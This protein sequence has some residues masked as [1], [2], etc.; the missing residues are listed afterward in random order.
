MSDSL[1]FRSRTQSSGDR[2]VEQIEAQTREVRSRSNRFALAEAVFVAGGIALLGCGALILLAFRLAPRGFAAAAWLILAGFVVIAVR[3]VAQARRE[4]IPARQA[5]VLIDE[6]A[7][8]EGRLSTLAAATDVSRR[9]R[10]WSFLLHEN[11]RLAPQWEPTRLVPR[12]IPRSVRFFAVALLVLAFALWRIPRPVSG[13][14][15][16]PREV[17]ASGPPS[18]NDSGEEGE[19][20]PEDSDSMPGW[21]ELPE[22]IR[23]AILGSQSSQT[24]AGKLPEKTVPVLEDK[25]G[26]AIVGDRMANGG[27]VRSMPAGPNA[28]KPSGKPGAGANAPPAPNP[29]PATAADAPPPPLLA[30]GDA[31][32]K[33]PPMDSGKPQGPTSKSKGK[34]APGSSGGGGA[35]AGGDADGLYGD[36]QE[37][38]KYSGSFALDLDALQSDQPSKEGDA[39]DVDVRPEGRLAAEQRL[40]DAIRRSQ[41]P[42][43][44]EKIVQRIF[45]R[46]GEDPQP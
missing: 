2:A 30:R 29:N 25:G 44:Y 40:D 34:S 10:L 42:V 16:S 9:S 24:F 5:A 22:T 35:G 18:E 19:Q 37:P 12:A 39:G 23:Q 15:E 31:P 33:L 13:A 3:K 45:N 7:R 20:G 43:E 1:P 8:L 38:G 17:A 4:W 21:T 28:P 14:A 41:V 32:K 46:A 11:L 26:P 36:K 6:R 27:P